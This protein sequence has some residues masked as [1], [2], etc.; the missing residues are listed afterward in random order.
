MVVICIHIVKS[1]MGS[2][3]KARVVV[4]SGVGKAYLVDGCGSGFDGICVGGVQRK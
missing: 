4:N 3:V 2:A 1:S